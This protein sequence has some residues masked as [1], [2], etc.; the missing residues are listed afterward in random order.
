MNK[1]FNVGD[2]VK[3]TKKVDMRNGEPFPWLDSMDLTIGAAGKITSVHSFNAGVAYAVEFDNGEVRGAFFLPESLEHI[4][5]AQFK[6]GDK[7]RNANDG[8][9]KWSSGALHPKR[10]DICTVIAV[11]HST[12][13]PGEQLIRLAEYEQESP[14]HFRRAN[15]YER[16]E[17]HPFKAGDL[18]TP[19]EQEHDTEGFTKGKP[20]KVR[21]YR[22]DTAFEVA[23]IYFESD[24]YGNPGRFRPASYYEH[25]KEQP[26]PVAE[27]RIRK[28][29]TTLR[30]LRGTS[31]ATQGE[32]EQ[33]VSRYTPGSVYEIVEVKVVRTVKVE[34]EV[35]VTDYKEAA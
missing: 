8:A 19:N 23:A 10:G 3:V 28:H 11:K 30:E 31:Y 2:K 5:T 24:N 26:E 32:A 14:Y 16:I 7:V 1:Q 22:P 12:E 35:R 15:K 13:W 27:F 17:D 4:E 20:Y 18:V 34:Q 9:E 25:Y 29:G 21:E 33:A 6:V